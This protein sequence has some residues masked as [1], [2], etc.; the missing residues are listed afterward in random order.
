MM[1]GVIVAGSVVL[2][3][4]HC[5]IEVITLSQLMITTYFLKSSVLADSLNLKKHT[6][7]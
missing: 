1:I 2:S 7:N 4:W 3:F 5:I 6:I